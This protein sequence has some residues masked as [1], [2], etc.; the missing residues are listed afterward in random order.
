[1]MYSDINAG[2][3]RKP[4]NTLSL[5]LGELAPT[6]QHSRSPGTT[7]QSEM[8]AAPK[9]SMCLLKRRRA[10]KSDAPTGLLFYFDRKHFGLAFL[11]RRCISQPFCE[12]AASI[13]CCLLVKPV[14]SELLSENH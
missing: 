10:L 9:F 6:G 7:S 11:V 4:R 8:R 3:L 13:R 5:S 2:P 12:V 1:M 14:A